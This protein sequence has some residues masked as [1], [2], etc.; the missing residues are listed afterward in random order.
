MELEGRVWKS[1]KSRF[2]IA[3]IPEIDFSTQ[4]S[5]RINALNMLKDA[6]EAVVHKRGFRAEIAFEKGNHFL[7]GANNQR[8]WTGFFLQQLRMKEGLSIAK[9]AK[10]MGFTSKTAYARYEQGKVTPSIE[11]LGQILE[12]IS[13]EKRAIL[14]FA[15]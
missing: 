10:R 12:A 15:A 1:S 5:S 3:H 14:R 13:S 4:G 9:V 8:Q 7:V 6:I 2:W 11:K